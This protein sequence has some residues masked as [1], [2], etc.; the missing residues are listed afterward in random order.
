MISKKAFENIPHAALKAAAE[1]FGFSLAILRWLLHIYRM[2]RSIRVGRVFTMSVSATRS[3]MPGDAF[4]D[5]LSFLYVIPVI[6]A[7]LDDF[8][9]AIVGVIADDVQHARVGKQE[10]VNEEL[11]SAAVSIIADFELKGVTV[12]TKPGKLV[13]LTYQ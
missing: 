6:D 10:S 1:R 11:T 7:M 4:A 9:D 8:P 13:M 12:A 3:I 2:P 5:L